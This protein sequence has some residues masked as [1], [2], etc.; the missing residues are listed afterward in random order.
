MPGYLA[1]IST[2]ERPNDLALLTSC[3]KLFAEGSRAANTREA[4]RFDFRHCEEWARRVG[5]DALA[6]ASQ[7]KPV[8]FATSLKLR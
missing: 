7:S 2:V 3:A 1:R 8:A 5:L 6:A 4:Y